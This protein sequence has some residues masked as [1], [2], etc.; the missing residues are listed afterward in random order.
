MH[1]P[2]RGISLVDML[3]AGA[4]SPV[5]FKGQVRRID[6]DIRFLRIR[7]HQD[8]RC[9]RMNPP[10]GLRLRHPLHTVRARFKFQ[11]TIHLAALDQ[12]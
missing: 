4:G 10:L 7:Q 8:G 11:L 2:D 3:A 9:R 6:F 5:C 12:K 1:D